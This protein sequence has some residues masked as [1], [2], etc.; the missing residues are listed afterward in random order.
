MFNFEKLEVWHKS[1]AYAGHT[2]RV[3]R[4]FPK[5]EQFGL[6]NQIRRAANS[7]SSNIAEGSARP[8]ADYC[9]FLGYAAGSL[10]EVVTQATIARNEG[11]LNPENY[12]QLYADA[13]EISRML[14][15]LRRL[16]GE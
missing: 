12:A 6:T 4:S 2:Y 14:S 9:R 8:P 3:T 10:F 7:V 5:E 16:L 11:F 13:E 15:G 1:I